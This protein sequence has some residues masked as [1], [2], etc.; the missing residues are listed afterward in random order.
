LAY[1]KICQT[2]HG[3][4]RL[5]P[6]R[7][8]PGHPDL[9]RLIPRNATPARP[10]QLRAAGLVVLSAVLALS[11]SPIHAQSQD[12][13]GAWQGTI[14]PGKELRLVFVIANAEGGALRATMHSIDQGG[15]AI[16]AIGG[17]FEGRL[18]ADGTS[19][20]GAPRASC[21][22]SRDVRSSRSTPTSST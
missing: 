19:I 9:S 6:W 10:G 7:H 3:P 20:I 21:S 5:K 17:T 15:Q 22:P 8:H 13:S 11:G 1:G 2:S 4:H 12:L 16:A 18:S 14:N